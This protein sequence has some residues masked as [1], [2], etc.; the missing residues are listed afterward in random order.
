MR[1]FGVFDGYFRQLAAFPLLV[2]T[3]YRI[4]KHETAAARRKLHQ[5]D[6]SLPAAGWVGGGGA[7]L[8]VLDEHGELLSN[9]SKTPRLPLSHPLGRGLLARWNR[10]G[11]PVK[12]RKPINSAGGM[13]ER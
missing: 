12:T 6:A 4:D 11:E 2:Y 9:R 3:A 10:L 5:V 7:P 8:R 13:G 1:Y